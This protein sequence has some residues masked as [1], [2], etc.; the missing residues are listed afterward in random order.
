M[1]TKKKKEMPEYIC[2]I[3]GQKKLGNGY[4]RHEASCRRKQ[5]LGEETMKLYPVTL[6]KARYNA[7]ATWCKENELTLAEGVDNLIAEKVG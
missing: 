4:A 7:F 2:P 1:M 6:P 3:C 5:A